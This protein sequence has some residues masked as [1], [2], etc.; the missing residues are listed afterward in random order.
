MNESEF[1]DW[2]RNQLR[3]FDN[4]LKA[5]E[6]RP[7]AGPK[8]VDVKLRGEMAA[9]AEGLTRRIREGSVASLG[10]A[11]IGTDGTPYTALGGTGEWY[12]LI[13]AVQTL[14]DELLHPDKERLTTP[15]AEETAA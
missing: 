15:P 2:M 9:L 4:R 5:V 7:E 6:A 14:N 10:I 11:F 8:P 13:G 3:A 1:R 12:A